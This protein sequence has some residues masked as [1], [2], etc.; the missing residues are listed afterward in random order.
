VNDEAGARLLACSSGP[1]PQLV[2]SR[3]AL[4]LHWAGV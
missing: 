4:G 3:L 1:L 2:V